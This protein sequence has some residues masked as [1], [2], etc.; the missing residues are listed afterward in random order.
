MFYK[1]PEKKYT[2]R[3]CECCEKKNSCN[4]VAGKKK[5]YQSHQRPEHQQYERMHGTPVIVSIVRCCQARTP[6][7]AIRI[8]KD[9]IHIEGRAIEDRSQD[10]VNDEKKTG[11]QK[12]S[13]DPGCKSFKVFQSA[14]RGG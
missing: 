4:F 3:A 14:A 11:H 2:Q 13:A 12:T 6:Q 7:Q 5:G 1:Q 9:V 8:E 10:E